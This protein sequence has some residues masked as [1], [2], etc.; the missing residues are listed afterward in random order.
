MPRKRPKGVVGVGWAC[1]ASAMLGRTEHVPMSKDY[2]DTLVRRTSFEAGGDLGWR[3]SALESPR[4]LPAPWKIV[5]VTGS[6]SWAE[7]WAPVLAALPADREMIV[8]DRPGFGASQPSDHVPDLDVQALALSPLLKA[9]P[10]QQILLVGQSYGAAIATLMARRHGRRV[11]GLVLLSGYYGE[12]GPTARWLL[13]TGGRALSLIPRDLRNAVLEVTGQPERLAPV[14]EALGRLPIPIHLIHGDRDDFAPLEAAERLVAETRAR[15]SIR[16]ERVPGADHFI[17]DGPAERLLAS[18]DAC[19]P[20]PR[21]RFPQV[22]WPVL[23]VP[24]LANV[25]AGLWARLPAGLR[26]RSW[27]GLSP[28]REAA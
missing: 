13:D 6:P 25:G 7:Y 12:P 3:I 27:P 4:D 18:L 10:G 2:P 20:A 15:R 5:V 14:R 28:T 23:A 1:F 22:R 24:S 26:D 17:N 16:L 8:V 11:R 21:R 19:L 9:A